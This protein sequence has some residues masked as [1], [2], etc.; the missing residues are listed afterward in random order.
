MFEF[1]L[2]QMQTQLL[3]TSVDFCESSNIKSIKMTV[4]HEFF[5][6]DIRI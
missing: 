1:P 3:D 5:E 4:Q 2:E 6:E